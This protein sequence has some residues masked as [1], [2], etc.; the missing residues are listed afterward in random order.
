[1]TNAR[2]LVS[3]FEL[4]GHMF[5]RTA[6]TLTILSCNIWLPVTSTIWLDKAS[7]GVDASS[8]LH[9]VFSGGG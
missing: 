4:T 9:G 7:I 8:A 5:G 2:I 1:M 6:M 3:Y